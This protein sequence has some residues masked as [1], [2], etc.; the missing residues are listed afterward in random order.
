MSAGQQRFKDVL[1]HQWQKLKWNSL[2]EATK[3]AIHLRD[4]LQDLSVEVQKPIEIFV[5]NQ[6]FKALSKQSTHYG[7]TKHF[8]LELHFI[9]EL[10]E[11][12]ELELK[13]LQTDLMIADVLTKGLGKTKHARFCAALFGDTEPERRGEGSQE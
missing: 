1:L 11:R 9:R 10:V 8:A 7:K 2:V 6:A 13:Y 5:D 3:E 4:L 12:G